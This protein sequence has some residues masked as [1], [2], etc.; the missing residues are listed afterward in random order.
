M[1]EKIKTPVEILAENLSNELMSE[2]SSVDG[3]SLDSSDVLIA[4]TKVLEANPEI[5]V[6]SSGVESILNLAEIKWH[7]KI[8]CIRSYEEESNSSAHRTYI[9]AEIN[10]IGEEGYEVYQIFRANEYSLLILARKPI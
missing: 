9:E 8:Y 7:N 5:H 10:K 2:M 6:I 3:Y 4:L 1:E